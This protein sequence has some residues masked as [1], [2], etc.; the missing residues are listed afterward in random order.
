MW[1]KVCQQDVPAIASPEEQVVRCAKCRQALTRPDTGEQLEQQRTP[2][3]APEQTTAPPGSASWLAKLALDQWEV[4]QDLHAARRLVE[5]CSAPR[6]S[7]SR[8]RLDTAHRLTS[9]AD[10]TQGAALELHRRSPAADAE[11]SVSAKWLLFVGA[12]SLGCGVLLLGAW[13]VTDRAE[14]WRL[15]IPAACAGQATLLVALV[16][17]AFALGRNHHATQRTLDELDSQLA[18]LQREVTQ[19]SSTSSPGQSFYRHLAEGA[20]PKLLLADLKGQLDL[21]ANRLADGH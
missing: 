20:S 15:G 17:E 11:L 19:L 21:L 14:F 2:K 6:R 16:L 7:Q 5:S 3:P 12:V 13:G 4:E 8:L 18:E 1:C 10:H 9:S